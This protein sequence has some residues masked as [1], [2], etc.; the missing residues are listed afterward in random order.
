[1]SDRSETEQYIQSHLS[2]A[3]SNRD[4]FSDKA[5]DEVFQGNNGNPPYDQPDLR[6]KPDVQLPAAETNH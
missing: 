4:I 1:M 6:K 2:Y 3:G 5:I